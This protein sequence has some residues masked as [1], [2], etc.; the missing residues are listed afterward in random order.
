LK[1]ADRPSPAIR[2]LSGCRWLRLESRQGRHSPPPRA[3]YR[4]PQR[5]HSANRNAGGRGAS[6]QRRLLSATNWRNRPEL[7]R[8][9]S[10]KPTFNHEA[11][12]IQR[13]E[14]AITTV[15]NNPSTTGESRA[16]FARVDAYRLLARTNCSLGR[17]LLVVEHAS[18]V[19]LP[20]AGAVDP[21]QKARRDLQCLVPSGK[22]GGPF[23]KPWRVAGAFLE[24]LAL[25]QHSKRA[26]A[27][28]YRWCDASSAS[29]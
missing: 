2:V 22:V 17:L 26:N 24:R 8:R 14:L 23:F 28:Y 11:A 16:D 7:A 1:I 6:R 20:V 19:Q 3:L 12:G 27:Q 5:R 25:R 9:S 18:S 10:G 15:S 13:D 29:R 21:G 4:N